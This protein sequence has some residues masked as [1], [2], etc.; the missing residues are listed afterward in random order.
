VT[1]VKRLVDTITGFTQGTLQVERVVLRRAAHG[2]A[3]LAK[4]GSALRRSPGCAWLSRGL[5]AGPPGLGAGKMVARRPGFAARA[6]CLK[7][8]GLAG[9]RG[10]LGPQQSRL[11]RPRATRTR[12]WLCAGVFAEW[13]PPAR[14]GKRGPGGRW[15]CHPGGGAAADLLC[16]RGRGGPHLPVRT[17]AGGGNSRARTQL[18]G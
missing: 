11:R 4:T 17:G 12:W 18:P 5:A 10:L 13:P 14:R 8:P 2:L 3:E 9:V 6:G 7:Q 16:R 1:Q 15:R